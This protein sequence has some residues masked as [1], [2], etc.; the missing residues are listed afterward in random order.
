MVSG[1]VQS[2]VQDGGEVPGGVQFP[3]CGGGSERRDGVGA[4][5]GQDDQ[6]PAERFPR[7]VVGDP[8]ERGLR[9]GGDLGEPRR[10]DDRFGADDDGVGVGIGGLPEA[11]GRV[12]GFP[13]LRSDRTGP[14][15]GSDDLDQHLYRRRR[16]DRAGGGDVVAV[17]FAA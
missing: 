9:V 14:A 12:G 2:V 3:R 10:A 15:V 17:T 13:L 11:A 16:R 1:G 7:R 5:S 8:R 6:V 4:A